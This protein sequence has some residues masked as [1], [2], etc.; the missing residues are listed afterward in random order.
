MLYKP[1]SY[2]NVYILRKALTTEIRFSPRDFDTIVMANTSVQGEGVTH[3]VRAH[4]KVTIHHILHTNDL[5]LIWRDL[6]VARFERV[7]VD[8]ITHG[9]SVLVDQ[10]SVVLGIVKQVR[11]L[12]A[13]FT[14]GS[15]C[16]VERSE[17]LWRR[18]LGVCVIDQVSADVT[19]HVTTETGDI[20]VV[21]GS[22]RKGFWECDGDVFNSI[23]LDDGTFSG[24]NHHVS[25]SL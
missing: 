18:T 7:C 15:I 8:H 5:V 24:D 21:R 16:L 23:E 4:V 6:R 22:W 9:F 1:E 25:T 20:V 11:H 14:R 12:K 19:I 13:L 17:L 2:K 10:L 3:A